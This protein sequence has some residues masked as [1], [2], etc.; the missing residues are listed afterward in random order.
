MALWL[1][2]GAQQ[3][4]P[5]PAVPATQA[6]AGEEPT[7][8]APDTASP[9]PAPL[10]A[11]ESLDLEWDQG[12]VSAS[13]RRM[14]DRVRASVVRIRGFYGANRAEAFHGTAFAVAPGGLL[15]TNYHV[16]ARAA[17]SPQSYRLE[18][19]TGEGKVGAV[20]ILAVDVAHD[21]AL[22][23]AENLD[24]PPLKLRTEDPPRGDRVYTVG[25]P[26]NLGLVITEGIGNGRLPNEFIPRLY[27]AGPMNP[28]MSGG[29]ALDSRGRVIGVN[30][31]FS[32][33]G[34]LVSFVVPAEFAAPL[35][36]RAAAPLTAGSLRNEVARQLRQHQATVLG[37]LPASFPVQIAAGYALPAELAPFVNCTARVVDPPVQRLLVQSVSCQ[38]GVALS[39]EPGLQT[40][41]FQ[42]SHDVL[43][44]DGLHAL[45]FAEQLRRSAAVVAA[46]RGTTPF[47][48]PY[49]CR[50]ATV[51]LDNFQAAVTLCARSYRLYEGLYDVTLVATSLNE[52]LRGFVSTA[53]LRGVD[54]SGGMKFFRRYLRAMQWTP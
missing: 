28:G 41:D 5:A 35:L 36:A 12:P 51:N 33:R 10:D 8:A 3:P 39:V 30:V 48:N 49:A 18:F 37:A 32:T 24:R 29:P 53:T 20:S 43:V 16:V 52:P 26:L 13:A 50:S 9:A 22:V 2:A 4:A 42:F 1:T 31:A 7:T 19:D 17:L 27:Y 40:G 14:L 6:A 47:T 38:A 11:D 23:R 21:L 34:Q 54:F 46:R 44:A 25:Y 15:L 45:Q